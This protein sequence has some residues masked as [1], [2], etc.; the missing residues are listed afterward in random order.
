MRRAGDAP[1]GRRGDTTLPVSRRIVPTRPDVI[2][3]V[4]SGRVTDDEILSYYQTPLIRDF[5]GTW[6]ELVDGSAITEMAVTPEGHRRLAEIAAANVD[7]LR[8]GR[9]AMVAQSEITYG[10]FRMWELQREGLGYDV[11]VF[12][13][14]DEALAWVSGS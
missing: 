7:R 8:G 11:H 14:A 13:D 1:G 10:M 6:R 5:S 9:V 12:R 2:A 4:L 3:T